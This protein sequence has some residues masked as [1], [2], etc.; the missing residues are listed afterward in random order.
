MS[1]ALWIASGYCIL[2]RECWVCKVVRRE[3]YLALETDRRKRQVLHEDR[4][5]AGTFSW[6]CVS[7]GFSST[8][9]C[10]HLE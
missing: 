1:T 10:C 8:C 6:V 5:L 3:P 2:P 9:C 4:V 7:L